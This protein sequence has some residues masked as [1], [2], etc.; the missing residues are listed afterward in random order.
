MHKTENCQLT[1]MCLLKV[2]SKIL[3]QLRHKKDWPGL[4][5]PGGHVEK[6]EG[7]KASM[8]REFYEETG[9]TLLDARLKGVEEFK[10]HKEDRY[11]IFFFVA[12][13]YEGILKSSTEGEVFWLE[14]KEI[15]KYDLSL[16]LVDILKVMED[17]NLSF[18]RYYYSDDKWEHCLE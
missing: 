11:F 13:K 1:N 10:T 5:L 3:V 9:L 18:L 17:K 4:T 14:E 12:S 2:G 6:K 8:I 16:D 15:N 7:L